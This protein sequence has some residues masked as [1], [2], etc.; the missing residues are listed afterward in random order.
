MDKFYIRLQHFQ[1]LFGLDNWTIKLEQASLEDK[2]HSV[3]TFADPRYYTAT[4]TIYPQALV[5]EADYDRLVVHELLHVVFAL[6]DFF[7]DNMSKEG[8]DELFFIAREKSISEA[9][10]IIMRILD[11]KDKTNKE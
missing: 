10:A 6:Y 9:T 11:E 3:M 7:A 5:N 2:N 8:S 4:M 1:K